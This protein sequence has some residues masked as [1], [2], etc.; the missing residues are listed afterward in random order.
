MSGQFGT[1]AKLSGAEMSHGQFDTGAEVSQGHFGTG[2]E[3]SWCRSVPVPKCPYPILPNITITLTHYC[4]KTPLTV[5]HLKANLRYGGPLPYNC[6]SKLVKQAAAALFAANLT[7][8]KYKSYYYFD[9]YYIFSYDSGD[10]CMSTILSLT[11]SK[12]SHA[13]VVFVVDDKLH[14]VKERRMLREV[15]KTTFGHCVMCEFYN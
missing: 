6:V 11:R 2:A 3:A 12:H 1:G 4:Q 13:T 15:D 8:D 9:F 14:C 10:K 7:E 5:N